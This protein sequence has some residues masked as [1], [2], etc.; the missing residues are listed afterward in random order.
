MGANAGFCLIRLRETRIRDLLA[1]A[2]DHRL[3]KT[4][5]QYTGGDVRAM[6]KCGRQMHCR[7]CPWW[8]PTSLF[9]GPRRVAEPAN[10]SQRRHRRQVLSCLET[11]PWPLELALARSTQ[12]ITDG[13]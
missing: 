7:S 1:H 12:G 6:N 2:R 8:R 4:S 13:S 9:V 5:E 3:R 10:R 11:K